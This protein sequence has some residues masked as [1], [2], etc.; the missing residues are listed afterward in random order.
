M[1]QIFFAT[2]AD[3]ILEAGKR[4]LDLVAFY[5]FAIVAVHGGF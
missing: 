2:A 3:R 4:S 5:V 1:A